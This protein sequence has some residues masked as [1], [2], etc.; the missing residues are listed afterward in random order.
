MH[1][2]GK[3]ISDTERTPWN[4]PHL[5]AL[6]LWMPVGSWLLAHLAPHTATAAWLALCLL[7]FGLAE[8][9]WPHRQTWLPLPRAM[10]LDAALLG[11]A[12]VV[13]GALRHG[14]VWMAQWVASDNPGWASDWPLVLAVPAAVLLGE[15]GP[16]ALHR[17]AHTHPGGWCWHRLHHAPEQVNTSNSVRVHPLNLAWNVVS[18]GLLWWG[19]GFSAEAL[20][21][22]TLFMMMQSV[23]VHANVRG[24]LGPLAWLIGS[25]EAHRWHHSTRPHEALNYGTAVPLWD[26]LFGTWHLP[27][28]PGLAAVGLYR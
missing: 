9:C 13:D 27:K 4:A 23:A 1:C 15:L 12:A 2:E 19:V 24:H 14:G 7:G 3:P 28:G 22:A 26:Q 25:A 21:W 16:Y 8:R 17:W 20:T 6:L 18:R 5:I 10:G 11:M